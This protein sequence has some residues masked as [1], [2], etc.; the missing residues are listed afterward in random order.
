[1]ALKDKA[2]DPNLKPDPELAAAVPGLRESDGTV[3]CA[4]AMRLAETKKIDPEAVGR[5]LDAM[6]VTLGRCQIG[7]FGY[8]GHAK[9]WTGAGLEAR[10]VPDGLENALREAGGND[11]SITCSDIWALASRFG[12]SRLHAGWLA[13][14]AGLKIRKCQLGAF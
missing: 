9:G 13:D 6:A 11:R 3:S 12:L 1:M 5:T 10:P 7:T 4:A 2:L 14:R 8:P